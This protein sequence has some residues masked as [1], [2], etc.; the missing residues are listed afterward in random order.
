MAKSYFKHAYFILLFIVSR[1]IW[2]VGKLKPWRTNQSTSLPY[3]LFSLDMATRLRVDSSAIK[4]SSSDFGNM[5]NKIPSAV[6]L[7]THITDIIDLVK[8]SYNSSSPFTIAARGHGHSVRGQATASNGVVVD[9]TSLNK[10][11]EIGNNIRVSWSSLLGFYADVGG[12]QLWID[13]LK[14]TLEHGLAPVSWTDY[15]YLTVGGTLSNAGV[16]GQTFLHGPQISNVHELDVV[17]GIYKNSITSLD[18]KIQIQ[19][20]RMRK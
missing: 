8:L 13:V 5:V 6:L 3:E 10:Y 7:P 1:S 18:E 19:K 20:V 12:E 2:I 15:L 14:A 9:M 16:S 4:M 11:S 17:T